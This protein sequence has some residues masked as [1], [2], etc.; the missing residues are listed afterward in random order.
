MPVTF[1]EMRDLFPPAIVKAV[2]DTLH[3]NGFM[4]VLRKSWGDD[5]CFRAQL[6][7]EFEGK[8]VRGYIA[9]EDES[10]THRVHEDGGF[11]FRIKGDD[12]EAYFFAVDSF[13]EWMKSRF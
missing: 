13:Y 7:V 4:P 5:G 9:V 11:A 3:E 2:V 6:T 10:W 12:D 8:V 1:S